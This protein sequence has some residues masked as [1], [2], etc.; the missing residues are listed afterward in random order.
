MLVDDLL[1]PLNV[2]ANTGIPLFRVGILFT[3]SPTI[4]CNC[5]GL[6]PL[7][8]SSRQSYTEPSRRAQLLHALDKPLPCQARRRRA[9]RLAVAD[10][11]LLPLAG[12]TALPRRTPH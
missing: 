11:R 2:G 6:M 10:L 1:E 3:A 5:R 8:S 4:A 9:W 7:H 12:A